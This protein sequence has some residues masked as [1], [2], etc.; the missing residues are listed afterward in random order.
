MSSKRIFLVLIVGIA[1]VTAITVGAKY[2]LNPLQRQ[3]NHV[4]YPSVTVP[5]IDTNSSVAPS[6]AFPSIHS[7]DVKDLKIINGNV[8]RIVSHKPPELLVDKNG[9]TYEGGSTGDINTFSLSPDGTKIYITVNPGISM[10]YL[11]YVNFSNGKTQYINF[12]SEA[13]WSHNSRYIAFSYK[14]ADAGPVTDVVVYDTQS[15]KQQLLA[16]ARIFPQIPNLTFDF[17]GYS[18]I[19]WVNNDSGVKVHYYAFKGNMPFGDKISEGD[20][21]LPI[22]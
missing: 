14:H 19:S 16:D 10:D 8:Y 9:C 11:C 21:V 3:T 6:S 13:A 4:E 2:I 5:E 22:K 20:I 7:E 15:E 17:L 18:N 1:I 12:A